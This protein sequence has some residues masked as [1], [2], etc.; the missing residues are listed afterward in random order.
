[1]EP[2]IDNIAVR[3]FDRWFESEYYRL[4]CFQR[5]TRLMKTFFTIPIFVSVS[6]CCLVGKKWRIIALT[7][8]SHT[9]VTD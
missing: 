3:R 1:M 2:G 6:A 4:R 7:S 5:F 8:W 9:A